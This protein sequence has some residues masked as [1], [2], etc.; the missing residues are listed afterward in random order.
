MLWFLVVVLIVRL[1][2]MLYWF[3]VVFY[4]IVLFMLLIISVLDGLK[5][6][7]NIKLYVIVCFGFEFFLFLR[8]W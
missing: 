7:E 4:K 2:V 3:D 5:N 6:N 1:E 8:M